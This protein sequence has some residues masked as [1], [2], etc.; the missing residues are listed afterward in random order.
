VDF[1]DQGNQNTDTGANATVQ[2]SRNQY[3]PYYLQSQFGSERKTSEREKTGTG[4]DVYRAS[5]D[6]TTRS[7]EQTL[8]DVT[9]WEDYDDTGSANTAARSSNNTG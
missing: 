3:E 6:N 7:G 9:R 8:L 2:F 5:A 4:G 1:T